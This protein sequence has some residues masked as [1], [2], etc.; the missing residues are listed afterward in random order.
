MLAQGKGHF[1]S[2]TVLVDVP[3]EADLNDEETFGPVAGLIKFETEADVIALAND[4]D[5]G[6]AG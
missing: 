3:R 6:L 5:V 4:T 2:P 1:Y